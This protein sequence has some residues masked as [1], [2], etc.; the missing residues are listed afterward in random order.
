M[1]SKDKRRAAVGGGLLAGVGLGSLLA[2]LLYIYEIA[3]RTVPTGYGPGY[4]NMALTTFVL[5][6][7]SGALGVGLGLVASALIRDDGG[8]QAGTATAADPS[9]AASSQKTRPSARTIFG[10][11]RGG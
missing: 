10:F 3:H 2:W 9:A 5:L 8:R 6:V 4:P 7:F 11:G 1:S